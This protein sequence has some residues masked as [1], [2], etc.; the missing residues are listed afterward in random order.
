MLKRYLA[1]ILLA[2]SVVG[3]VPLL[4]SCSSSN[5]APFRAAEPQ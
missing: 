5:T 3:V 2:V 1:T 4:T